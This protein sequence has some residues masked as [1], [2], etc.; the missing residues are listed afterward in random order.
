MEVERVGRSVAWSIALVV[1]MSWAGRP[2]T[3][4][5]ESTTSDTERLV[6]E[7]NDFALDLYH[8]LCAERGNL[9]FS[10]YLISK[11]MAI[12]YAGAKNETERQIAE[13]LHFTL[14]QKQLHPAFNA[15]M[16]LDEADEQKDG[17]K[18]YM[19]NALW[20][21]EG[22]VFL[23]G[24]IDIAQRGYETALHEVDFPGSLEKARLE[25]N[26]WA[27]KQTGTTLGELL[28]PGDLSRET[29]LAVTNVIRFK[30][31]WAVPFLDRKSVV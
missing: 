16:L 22:S 9:C 10:P 1:I 6:Q 25:I 23:E 28:K 11:S 31:R 19:A 3:S 21:Q 29:L 15:L 12:T 30:G 5:A 20:K 17:Y 27:A 4:A 14:P 26:E 24:F 13:V 8:Q 2:I 7:N 18:L